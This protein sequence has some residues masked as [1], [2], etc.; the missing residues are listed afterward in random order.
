MSIHV[1]KRTDVLE[2]GEQ[3]KEK[4][5]STGAG[6]GTTGERWRPEEKDREAGEVTISCCVRGN[7]PRGLGS[8][9]RGRQ[10]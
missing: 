5:R 6:H 3:T 8:H 1:G 4:E 2:E 7:D 9:E 10:G